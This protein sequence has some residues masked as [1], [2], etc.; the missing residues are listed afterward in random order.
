MRTL[1]VPV[2]P[3]FAAAAALLIASAAASSPTRWEKSSDAQTPIVVMVQEVQGRV[4][5]R[6]NSKTARDPLR[7][8]GQ[9][10]GRYGGNYPVIVLVDANAQ[11][12]ELDADYI[13]VARE[14]YG[15]WRHRT[16]DVH[17][18]R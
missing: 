17:C 15:R 4:V 6:V 16:A 10:A 11:A 7:S 13:E 1:T 3:A 12:T 14:C 2:I 5:Y 9:L 8:L 18:A